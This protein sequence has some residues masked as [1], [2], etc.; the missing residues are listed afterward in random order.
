MDLR[1]SPFDFRVTRALHGITHLPTAVATYAVIGGV[2][3]YAR[4]I[5][6]NDLPVDAADFDRWICRRVLSPAAPLFGEIELPLSEDPAT[7]KANT[8]QLR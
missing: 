8:V 5:S 7:S 3:A 1:V 4:E 6:E 2:A